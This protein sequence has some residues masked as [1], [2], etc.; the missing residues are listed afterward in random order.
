MPKKQIEE[1]LSKSRLCPF[2]ASGDDFDRAFARYQWNIK[3]S[4]AMLP[5]LHYL[6][7]TLRNKLNGVIADLYGA[8]WLVERSAHLI[9]DEQGK[10]L[11][12]VRDRHLRGK[13]SPPAQDDYVAHMSF[14]FWC[15]YFHKS[16]DPILW[17]KKGVIAKLF[18]YGREGDNQR[19]IVQDKL[20]MIKKIRNRIAHHEAIWN[21]EPNVEKIHYMCCQI[22]GAI[23]PD[24]LTCLAQIDRFPSVWI[25]FQSSTQE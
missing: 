17:H 3:L 9:S 20:A 21:A 14:G 19:H 24:A 10:I 15:A 18:P 22:I 25:E 1:I 11:S 23:S 13:K 4:E 16:F 12:E 6:E 5:V 8:S 2:Y 7:I